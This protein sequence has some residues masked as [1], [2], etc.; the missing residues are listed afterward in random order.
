MEN[1]KAITIVVTANFKFCPKNDNQIQ[2]NSKYQTRKLNYVYC[3]PIHNGSYLIWRFLG[4]SQIHQVELKSLPA[5]NH[6]KVYHFHHHL[7]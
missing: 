4:P 3:K 2:K 7:A 1:F 5:I 6:F